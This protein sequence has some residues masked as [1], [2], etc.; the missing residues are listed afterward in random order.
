MIDTTR[1]FIF[2]HIP[3]TAGCSVY[4]ALNIQDSSQR[5]H[6]PLYMYRNLFIYKKRYKQYKEYFKFAFVRNP[7]DRFISCY[8]YLKNGGRGSDANIKDSLLVNQYNS[9]K[10]FV[11]N[12]KNIKNQFTGFHFLSQV[13]W[14]NSSINF[15]G[16]YERLEC[17]FKYVCD[18]LQL[19][20]Y[21]LPHTNITH[22]SHYTDY[23]DSETIK[24]I[25]EEYAKDIEILNYKF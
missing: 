22:H 25:A 4:E 3:K 12:F 11:L 20:Y 17:D 14:I 9:F 24:I 8:F 16:R 23:Y 15:I 5:R 10:D 18:M 19:T 2:I 13:Q 1:K 6:V 7:W 21:K